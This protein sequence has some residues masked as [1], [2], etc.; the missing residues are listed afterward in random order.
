VTIR[1]RIQKGT[2]KRPT[3]RKCILR[4]TD[5]GDVRGETRTEGKR[6]LLTPSALIRRTMKEAT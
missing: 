1:S 2:L 6:N 4:E 3:P 5:R